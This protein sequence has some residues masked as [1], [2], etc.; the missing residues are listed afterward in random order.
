MALFLTGLNRI[1]FHKHFNFEFQSE[2]YMKMAVSQIETSVND[3]ILQVAREQEIQILELN[4]QKRVVDD[5][6]FTSLDVATLTALLE[7]TFKV[8]PFGSGLASIT[9][10]RTLQDIYNLYNR[11]INGVGKTPDKNLNVLEESE[12]ARLKKRMQKKAS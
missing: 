10:I 3:C 4:S 7:N 2:V 12:A 11:C 1:A 6:G 5:L 8:D 9:E